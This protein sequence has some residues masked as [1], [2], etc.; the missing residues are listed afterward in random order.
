MAK[1]VGVRVDRGSRRQF[2]G[3]V[4]MIPPAIYDHL[5]ESIDSS[6]DDEF[7][8]GVLSGLATAA[9][10]IQMNAPLYYIPQLAA[11][12]ADVLEEREAAV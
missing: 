1:A 4:G 6:H 9:T 3:Q 11:V 2:S 5:R 7:M 12:L 8:A 10:F